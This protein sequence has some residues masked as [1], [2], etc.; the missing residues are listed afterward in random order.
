[1]S[2]ETW[3]NILYTYG[4]FAILVFL[5]IVIE[6]KV[7][8]AWKQS[9]KNNA[10]E[11]T[12]F[13]RLYGVTWVVIFCATVCCIYAWWQINLSRRPQITGRIENLPNTE[14]V[15]TTCADLFLHKNPKGGG[16]SD[17]D[18]LLINKDHKQWA[19]GAKV[20]FIIQTPNSNSEEE[21][22]IEYSLLIRSAF[23]RTGVV[24]RRSEKGLILD[25]DGKE[26]ELEGRPLSI[27]TVPAVAQLE[28]T[29]STWS[30][31]PTA[32]AQ[33]K[34]AQQQTQQGFSSYELMAGLESPDAIVRRKTRYQLSIQDQH[35]A[36]PL[37]NDILKDGASSYRLRIGAL[38]ALNNMPNLP[39][40]SL[41]PETIRAIQNSINDPD[42]VLRNEALAL[43]K[44]YKL[45]P[46][47]IYEHED[48][49]GRSQA[50]GP[51]TYRYDQL[52]L[53]S[54]PND[55]AS[56]VSVARGFRVRLCDNEGG[57]KGSGLCETFGAG[58]YKLGGGPGALGDKVSFIEVFAVK[59]N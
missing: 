50:Y 13:R 15:S 40:Q 16:Y 27:N 49:T 17:Y 22:L 23:Y 14:L 32:H 47:T 19:D 28:P 58:T 6:R 12:F 33:T 43:A 34:G 7:R 10:G 42:E 59:E 39:A 20:K 55:S 31:I 56:S 57:G 5:V 29:D 24:L 44:K 36:L 8:L 21:D 30:L 45:I 41:Y 54:L 2:P 25:H 46:V 37:I 38:V 3:S 4:P 53:G 35:L 9:D 18:L 51:G 52:R 48:F 26:T 11:Q 1:M